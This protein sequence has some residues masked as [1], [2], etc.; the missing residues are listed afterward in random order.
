[1][2][3]LKEDSQRQGGESLGEK[4][5]RR[6]NYIKLEVKNIERRAVIGIWHHSACLADADSRRRILLWRLQMV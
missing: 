5:G 1:M 6:L 4:E 3:I 2:I